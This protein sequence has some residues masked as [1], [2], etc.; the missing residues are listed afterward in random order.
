V[1]SDWS[2]IHGE[3]DG[4]E[5][6]RD[7]SGA[8]ITPQYLA[9]AARQAEDGF[10]LANARAIVYFADHPSDAPTPLTLPAELRLRAEAEARRRGCTLSELACEALE[11]HLAS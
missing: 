9:D 1:S 3:I 11:R 6:L 8:L 2:R 4:S 10:D 5:G 7:A